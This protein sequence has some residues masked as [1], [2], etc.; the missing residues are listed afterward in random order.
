MIREQISHEI[1]HKNLLARFEELI[2]SADYNGKFS[3]RYFSNTESAA[4]GF[5]NMLKGKQNLDLG[6]Q[7]WSRSPFAFSEGY[8]SVG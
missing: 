4:S 8:P 5:Y 6:I 2:F 3:Y 1:C 7:S